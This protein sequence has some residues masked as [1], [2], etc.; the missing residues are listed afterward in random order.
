MKRRDF[1]ASLP[2]T[3]AAS[4]LFAQDKN[5]PSPE[6]QA[7]REKGQ[8]LAGKPLAEL[9]AEFQKDLDEYVDFFLRHGID[10][11]KGGFMCSL[12]HD[13]TLVDTNK[14]HWFQGRGIWVFSHLYLHFKKDIRFLDVAKKTCD[15]MLRYFPQDKER[16]RWAAVVAKDGGVVRGYEKD[17]FGCYF[18]IEGMFELAGAAG[19]EKLFGEALD[20]YLRHYSF[21]RDPRI[22]AEDSPPG[23]RGFN[24]EMADLQI[25]T[26]ILRRKDIP[27]GKRIADDC[28]AA[29]MDRFYNPEIKL[30]NEV[31]DR[32]LNR[33]PELRN[34]AN[35]GHGV[36]IMWLV[37]DEALRRGDP[38]L[39][40]RAKERILDLLDIGWD[41]VYGGIVNGVHVGAGCYE[42]PVVKPAGMTVEFKE[43][44]EYNY[45]KA[46]WAISEVLIATLM[47]F[48]H[49][50][51]EWAARYFS[52]AKEVNDQK[53][54]LR[55]HGFP[56]HLL[57]T[58]RQFTY[59]PH[60]MR[61][62]NYHYLRALMHCLKALD[63]LIARDRS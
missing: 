12:G 41:H 29:I 14:F 62:D 19:D 47:I 10:H 25:A 33:I 6:D 35:P 17:P 48:E 54:S 44:G 40:D 36:E 59:Q 9:R 11:E 7:G 43:R 28:V 32:D 37:M 38:A 8:I 21:V 18:G 26:Q 42:W 24:L 5:L 23:R 51:E 20:L 52:R 31:L 3:A 46:Q 30:F 57:F 60:T 53:L 55:P 4:S 34:Q 58:D 63:R 16:M 1:L 50:G 22:L 61:K 27:E 45:V 39:F 49:R 2:A 13:G 56:L 15:F